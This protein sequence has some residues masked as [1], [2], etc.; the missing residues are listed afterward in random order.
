MAFLKYTLIYMETIDVL[1]VRITFYF[2]IVRLS[3]C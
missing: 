2:I 1:N 3:L